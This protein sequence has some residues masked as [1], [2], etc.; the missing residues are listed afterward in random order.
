MLITISGFFGSGGDELGRELSRRLD[1]K[2]YDNELMEKAVRESGI[3]MRRSTLAFYDEDDDGLDGLSGDTYHSALLSLQMDVLPIGS[4]DP[5]PVVRNYKADVLS[6]YMDSAPISVQRR[7]IPVIHRKDEIERLRF[8][9]AKVVLD[10][11]EQGN[12]VF[13]G[14]CSSYILGRRDDTLRI[15]TYASLDSC[16]E[17]IRHHFD[18]PDDGKADELIRKTNMRRGI[19]FETFTGQKWDDLKNYDLC[20]NTD[21]LSF[22]GALDLI[23]KAI[24][25]RS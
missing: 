25:A 24:A 14:R 5:E 12:A 20:I 8:A 3:D 7:T 19:Y 18:I 17:R 10:A 9:Q 16:R 23:L 11:A 21:A 2:T 6:L 1:Y 15:F 13:F 22:D 4:K